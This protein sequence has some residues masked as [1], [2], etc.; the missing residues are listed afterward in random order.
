MLCYVL[1]SLWEPNTACSGTLLTEQGAPGHRASDT[2]ET[3]V[4]VSLLYST[5]RGLEASA[6]W[7]TQNPGLE[8]RV[9]SRFDL[10]RRW[11]SLAQS[12]AAAVVSGVGDTA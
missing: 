12:E 6:F 10:Q 5:I 7:I 9:G 11:G 8:C 1:W 3:T 2:R 4:L